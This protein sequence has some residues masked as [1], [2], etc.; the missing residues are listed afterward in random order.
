MCQVLLVQVLGK[1]SALLNICSSRERETINNKI[2]II[3]T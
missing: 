1:I 3:K 2:I